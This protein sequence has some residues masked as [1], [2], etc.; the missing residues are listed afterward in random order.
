MAYDINL[1]DRVREFLAEVPNIEVGE[2]EMFATLNFMVNGKT[3]VC[4]SGENLMLRFDPKRQEELS[5]KDGYETM[6]M[7]G[8]EYKGYCYIN[9]EGFRN[10]N[11]FEYFINLCLDYN[12]VSKK[13][14]KKIITS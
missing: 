11:D 8:K 10:K 1:A 2:K 6:L 5:E 3:C 7:K 12:K 9:P 13:S 4:V 14:K